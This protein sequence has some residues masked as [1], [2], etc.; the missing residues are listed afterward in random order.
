MQVFRLKA[1]F[2]VSTML[3]SSSDESSLRKKR[4]H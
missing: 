3:G 4:N 1:T 2:S